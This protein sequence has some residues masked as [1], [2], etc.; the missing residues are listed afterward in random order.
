MAGVSSR[1]QSVELGGHWPQRDCGAGE[2][3]A[4]PRLGAGRCHW[5]KP[6]VITENSLL[7]HTAVLLGACT[8]CRCWARLHPL[9]V[10]ELPFTYAA[11]AS[12][13]CSVLSEHGSSGGRNRAAGRQGT[14]GRGG[15]GQVGA[16][17]VGQDPSCAHCSL[18]AHS[19]FQGARIP[20]LGP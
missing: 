1:Q 17:R 2:W 4:R 19:S 15:R 13:N 11:G 5:G 3:V 14:E 8:C 18:T 10:S 12:P 6:L 20:A 9:P 7:L 16:Q